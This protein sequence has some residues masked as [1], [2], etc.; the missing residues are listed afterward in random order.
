[1]HFLISAHYITI[2]S[3][4]EM[5]FTVV[6][7]GKYLLTKHDVLDYSI[8]KRIEESVHSIGRSKLTDLYEPLLGAPA[9]T[10]F[11]FLFQTASSTYSSI[12]VIV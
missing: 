9:K 1:M 11:V 4:I 3:W 5:I 10:L 8:V 12:Y 6:W 7:M 2:T